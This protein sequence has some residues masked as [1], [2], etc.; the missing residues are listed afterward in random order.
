[1]FKR[2]VYIIFFIGLE[3]ICL[4]QNKQLADSTSTTQIDNLK[5]QLLTVKNDSLRVRVIQSIGG[6][7]EV[8]NIDSSLKYTQ[9]GLALAKKYN[10]A[11]GEAALMTD[12]ATVFREQGKLAESLD[13]LLQSLEIAKANNI[14]FEIARA[15]RRL[16]DIYMDLGN[17][18]KAIG[19]L[20]QALK[21]D[22][23][24]QHKKSFLVDC[25]TLGYAY[26]KIN[27]LDSASFYIN[28][29]FQ[30]PDFWGQYIYQVLGNIEFKK[31]N[32]NKAAWFLREGLSI[33][34]KDNDL[35]TAS[36]ICAD[37]STLFIKLNKKD[38]AIYYASKGFEYGEQVSFKRALC[39]TAIL[40]QIYMTQPNL[41]WQL[42]IIK[43]LRLQKT[44]YLELITFK[45][46]NNLFPAKR[47][48]KKN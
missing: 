48:N 9:I 23:E 39:L 14:N 38:S 31:G 17:F 29:A 22:K 15:Y 46:Y 43:L 8:L 10:Y 7:Y 3:L 33:S 19:D 26:E 4:S 41:R 47:Q 32:Y 30:Q 1:M 25:M 45:Q 21:I 5:K 2:L 16:S 40:W 12:L 13:L 11:W 24:N 6:N 28:I 27:K 35:L 34:Q 37:I 20:L 18:T 42:N 44:G 36:E